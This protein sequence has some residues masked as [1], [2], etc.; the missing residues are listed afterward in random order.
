MS[1][2]VSHPSKGPSGTASV[3]YVQALLDYLVATDRNPHTL[4]SADE[5]D[6][7]VLPGRRIPIARWQAML[8]D[9]IAATGE[10]DL[11]LRMAAHLQ[12]RHLGLLGFAA[13]SSRVLG[14]LIQILLRYERLVDDV[15]ETHQVD[16]GD[17]VE[18]HWIP[19]HGP[20]SPVFM[21]LSL[22]GWTQI[23]RRLTRQSILPRAAHFSFPRPRKLDEYRRIFGDA[24]YFDAPVTKLVIARS[25]LDLPIR[26]SA[27]D[28]HR[29]L[30]RQIEADLQAMLLPDFAQR[31][32]EYLVRQLPGGRVGLEETAAHFRIA[33][34]TLQYRLRAMGLSYRGLLEQT[35]KELARRY[36]DGTNM[37]LTE[38]AVLLGYSEQAAFHHAFLRWTG[39]TPGR[40]RTGRSGV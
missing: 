14:D 10:A 24:L 18:L 19:L 2:P 11:P 6:D 38:V 21:Q 28:T 1:Q 29:V 35:R 4:F 37:S 17:A 5:L 23:G 40:F 7:T 15:N 31:L 3:A 13:M 33:P 36:L 16:S 25:M 26:D 32:R 8:E 27:P 9:A 20:A 30:M 22:A 34:R 12:P 39:T